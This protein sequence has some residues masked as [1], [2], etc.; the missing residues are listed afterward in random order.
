MIL[1]NLSFAALV[2]WK[3]PV[4]QRVQYSSE[5]PTTCEGN[6]SESEHKGAEVKVFC[7]LPLVPHTEHL[8]KTVLEISSRSRK[9]KIC[10]LR[11]KVTHIIIM[12]VYNG[13]V[14][15]NELSVINVDLIVFKDIKLQQPYRRVLFEEFVYLRST[16]TN[17]KQSTD[18]NFRVCED[19]TLLK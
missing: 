18:L 16:N 15:R 9:C 5:A 13:I 10:H 6:A 14:L 3:W 12:Q 19:S 11:R 1:P 2:L 7:C 8:V 17:Q 4:V